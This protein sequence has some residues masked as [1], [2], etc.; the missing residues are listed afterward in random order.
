MK[1]ILKQPNELDITPK[2]PNNFSFFRNFSDIWYPWKK[3]KILWGK[4]SHLR[5]GIEDFS[6][7]Y[8]R[9]QG[10]KSPAPQH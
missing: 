8:L 10:N 7:K 3:V 5:R 2:Y 9:V 6:L 4:F 1:N